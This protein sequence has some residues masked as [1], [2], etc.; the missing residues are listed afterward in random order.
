MHEAARVGM[1]DGE[2][3]C[4]TDMMQETRVLV[5][6]R[7]RAVHSMKPVASRW[8]LIGKHAAVASCVK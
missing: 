5:I 4:L 3:G 7:R 1:M 2:F 6:W 8:L